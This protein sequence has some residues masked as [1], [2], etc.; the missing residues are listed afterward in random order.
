MVWLVSLFWE[1]RWRRVT[2]SIAGALVETCLD[3]STNLLVCPA[4]VK[5]DEVCPKDSDSIRSTVSGPTFF[6]VEDL[7]YHLKSHLMSNEAKRIIIR[8]EEEEEG[9]EEEAEE[10]G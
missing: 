5:I 2:L 6:T 3:P 1:P 9:V 4:C 8:R 10:E 7:I